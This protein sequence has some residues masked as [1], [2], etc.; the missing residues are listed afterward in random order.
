MELLTSLAVWLSEL[1]LSLSD[2]GQEEIM[3]FF[4][5]TPPIGEGR[6][7]RQTMCHELLCC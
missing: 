2:G 1:T 3:G 7:T 6:K 5:V 4:F